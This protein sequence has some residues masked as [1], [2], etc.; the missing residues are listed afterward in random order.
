MRTFLDIQIS[1]G[2]VAEALDEWAYVR[3]MIEKQLTNEKDT[4]LWSFSYKKKE[5]PYCECYAEG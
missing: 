1:A 5:Q 4:C 3:D 2:S